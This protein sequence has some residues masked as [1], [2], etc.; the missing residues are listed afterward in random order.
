[1]MKYG[2]LQ[3]QELKFSRFLPRVEKRDEQWI[4]VELRFEL[5]NDTRLPADCSD[6]TIMAVCSRDGDIFQM[7]VQ[8]EGCDCEYQLTPDEKEQV[9]RYIEHELDMKETAGKLNR[10]T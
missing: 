6:V 5:G 4:D 7:F 1:M 3:P 10:T 9:R 8:D 2:D